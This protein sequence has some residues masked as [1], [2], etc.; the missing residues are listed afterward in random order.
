MT[1]ALS[2]SY[3][4]AVTLLRKAGH[5]LTEEALELEWLAIDSLKIDQGE[6]PIRKAARKLFLDQ[7]D[8]IL[9]RLHLHADDIGKA[10]HDAY[11]M[12]MI[13]MHV[14]AIDKGL[15]APSWTKDPLILSR[16]FPIS[17]WREEAAKRFRGIFE[18]VMGLGFDL[19]AVRAQVSGLQFT[20]STVGAQY[21]LSRSIA[22]IRDVNETTATG[23]LR[24]IT[25]WSES[26]ETSTEALGQMIASQFEQYSIGRAGR[27]A[28][29]SSATLFE[30]GQQE[31]YK[32]ADIEQKQWLSSRDGKVRQGEYDHVEPDGQIVALDDPFQVSGEALMFPADPA[33]SPGN[34][35]ECRCTSLPV[36][37]KDDAE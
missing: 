28:R 24:T 26:S 7:R 22:K 3:I 17:A 19:G 34:T 36:L 37:K 4:E 12:T 16:L 13:R 30:G 21:T 18:R 20:S 2:Y 14:E 6:P 29:T 25:R 32:E 11:Q 15:P 10:R 31:A 23:L 35:I 27:I 33:G 8:D 9:A 1:P 5:T